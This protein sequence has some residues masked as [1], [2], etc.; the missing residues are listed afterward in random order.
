ME[1]E[2]GNE[3]GMRSVMLEYESECS[4]FSTQ[5]NIQGTKSA[6]RLPTPTIEASL[7]RSAPLSSALISPKLTTRDGS[8]E[9]DRLG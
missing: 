3:G 6:T 4:V 2:G 8:Q 1:C 9:E 5:R 7:S